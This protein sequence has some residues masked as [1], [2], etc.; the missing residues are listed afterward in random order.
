MDIP[1]ALHY[2]GTGKVNGQL[3]GLTGTISSAI[4]VYNLWGKPVQ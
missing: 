4:A 2:M 3:A 1:T